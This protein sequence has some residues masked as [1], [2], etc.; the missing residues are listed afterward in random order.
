[1]SSEPP[2]P[3]LLRELDWYVQPIFGPDGRT[4]AAFEA[5]LRR[6]RPDGTV[7]GPN[8]LL[9]W[10]LHRD[11]RDAFTRFTIQRL[12]SLVVQVAE[13]RPDAPPLHLNLAPEQLL[14]IESER[15]FG[16]LRPDLRP[17]LRIEL[18]EQSVRD[19]SG[20]AAAVARLAATGTQVWLDDLDPHDLNERWPESLPRAAVSGV[21]LDRGAT[22]DLLAEPSGASAAMIRRLVSAGVHV[23]AEGIEDR[24]AL[25]LLRSLGID[26]FQGFA[27]G[28]PVPDL[29]AAVHR[30][31]PS[32]PAVAGNDGPLQPPGR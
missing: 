19:L 4:P 10:L 1:M 5:L 27:L 32:A 26:R 8:D 20:Y 6:P 14:S 16:Q 22:V 23:V 24:E 11:R 25:P 12:A 3:L 29:L 18:T 13:R 9:P 31:L 21:K 28:R 30:W 15:W 17:R 2:D 7:Q